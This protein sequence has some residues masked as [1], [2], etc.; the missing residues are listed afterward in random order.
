MKY[1]VNPL[2]FA[3]CATA[4]GI[5]KAI[6]CDFAKGP[7]ALRYGLRGLAISIPYVVVNEVVSGMLIRGYGR[8]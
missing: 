5:S 4:F 2:L 6:Y 3:S 1:A 7:T 8:E